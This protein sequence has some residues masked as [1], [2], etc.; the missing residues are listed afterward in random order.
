MSQSYSQQQQQRDKDINLGKD[1][2]SD[3]KGQDLSKQGL[4]SDIKSGMMGMEGGKFQSEAQRLEQERL[5]QQQFIGAGA[6]GVLP[7]QQQQYGKQ[8]VVGSM[9][10]VGFEQKDISKESRQQNLGGQS[11]GYSGQNR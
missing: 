11:S 10:G 5:R 9:G 8:D 2:K 4:Q 6:G 1:V 3:I 7:G